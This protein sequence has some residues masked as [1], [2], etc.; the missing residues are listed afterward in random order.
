METSVQ[1]ETELFR[2]ISFH[3]PSTES[4]VY[5]PFSLVCALTLIVF[6][7]NGTSRSEL[8]NSL[9]G[10]S[11]LDNSTLTGL[12]QSVK[13]AVDANDT[14]FSNFL[15]V[16]EAFDISPKFLNDSNNLVQTKVSRVSFHN[17]SANAVNTINDQVNEATN[18]KISKVVD[19]LSPE[20]KLVLLNAL[21]F[22]SDWRYKFDKRRTKKRAFHLEDGEVRPVEMMFTMAT[23]E[24]GFSDEMNCAAI[25]V[26]F[27]G[28]KASFVIFLPQINVTVNSVIEKMAP[29]SLSN[30]FEKQMVR[31]KVKLWFPKIQLNWS[32]SLV[33]YLRVL[34]I[35]DIFDP[36]KSDLTG[37]SQQSSGLYLSDIFHKVIFEADENGSRAAAATAAIFRQRSLSFAED[38]LVNRPFAFLIANFDRSK[39]SN[40]LFMGKYMSP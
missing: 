24:I 23:L 5:S 16:D 17:N 14:N 2:S 22:K 32:R 4:V 1:F 31:S 37:L 10:L 12:A 40:I 29:S 39:L 18:G 6:G 30:L 3:T 11:E 33:P 27:D 19:H 15:F 38:F 21:H 7:S 36:E 28:G 20:T 9:Y 8:T 35:N 25:K 26:P 34:G 13:S